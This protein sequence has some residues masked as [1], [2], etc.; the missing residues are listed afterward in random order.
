M[1]KSHLNIEKHKNNTFQRRKTEKRL[2]NVPK[3]L[4]AEH[5]VGNEF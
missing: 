1:Y 4:Q 2:N 3:T 5:A